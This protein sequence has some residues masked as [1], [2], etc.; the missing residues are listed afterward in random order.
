MTSSRP[1]QHSAAAHLIL[2]L[3]LVL[4]AAISHALWNAFVK[5]SGE[6]TFT[7]AVVLL[8]PAVAGVVLVL[9]RRMSRQMTLPGPS[10]IEFSGAS[11]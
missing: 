9:V 11:R 7:M 2:T 3:F 8:G 1:R 6:R 4:I 5:T 10:Q